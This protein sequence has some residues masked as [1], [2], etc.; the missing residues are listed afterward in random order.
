MGGLLEVCCSGHAVCRPRHSGGVWLARVLTYLRHQMGGL[1]NRIIGCSDPGRLA[2]PVAECSRLQ[3]W[4]WVVDGERVSQV[5]ALCKRELPKRF[6]Q[7]AVLQQNNE[8]L[9]AFD[10]ALFQG[11]WRCAQGG[12]LGRRYSPKVLVA[13]R[14]MVMTR[15]CWTECVLAACSPRPNLPNYS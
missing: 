8:V 5:C 11:P 3:A 15:S 9:A 14:A 12:L 10:C 4:S 7:E 1:K 2:C 6:R 13:S